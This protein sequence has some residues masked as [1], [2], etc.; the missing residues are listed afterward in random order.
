MDGEP[1]ASEGVVRTAGDTERSP[2]VR[3]I[4][5]VRGR[6]LPS[7]GST[8]WRAGN[9]MRNDRYVHTWR[10]YE[11]RAIV[12]FHIVA[13]TW[14]TRYGRYV[15]ELIDPVAWVTGGEGGGGCR[16]RC[17]RSRPKQKPFG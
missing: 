9:R 10:R 6:V 1:A 14:S 16:I 7:V 11:V 4:G 13:S 2:A 17:Q 12:D 8:L 15:L 3:G 5:G